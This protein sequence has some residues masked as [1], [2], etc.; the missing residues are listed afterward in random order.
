MGGYSSLNV[1]R[2]IHGVADQR[3]TG[4]DRRGDLVV[5]SPEQAQPTCACG[6]SEQYQYREPGFQPKRRQALGRS[7]VDGVVLNDLRKTQPYVIDDADGEHRDLDDGA[8]S[9]PEIRPTEG[10]ADRR[11]RPD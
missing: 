11:S 3:E 10:P 1:C 5:P 7:R 8:R 6:E 4:D 9:A 2:D